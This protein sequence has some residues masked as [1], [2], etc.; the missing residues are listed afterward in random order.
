[1]A[2]YKSVREVSAVIVNWQSY[3]LVGSCIAALKAGTS[4][5]PLEIIVI[6]NSQDEVGRALLRQM[7]D[8]RVEWI[9]NLTNVGFAAACNQGIG[10]A[11]SDYVL[12]I[13]PDA[14]VHER[15]VDDMAQ[16]IDLHP[17]LAA[18]GAQLLNPDGTLQPSA[19]RLY[20]GLLRAFLDLT[21]LRYAWLFIRRSRRNA[22]ER[23]TVTLMQTAWLKGACMMIR[24]EAFD[25]I[26]P[27]DESFFLFAEDVDWCYRAHRAGWQIALATDCFATHVGERSMSK[28]RLAGISAYYA[29]YLHFILKHQ[30][31]GPLGLRSAAARLLL[32]LGAAT[33]LIAFA[34][35]SLFRPERRSNAQAYWRYLTAH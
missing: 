15:T 31:P 16:L 9:F 23:E 5:I 19:Y 3:D 11:R 6:D 21:G 26:G 7:S 27:L 12:L 22:A 1:L 4:H 33:R 34:A 25:A 2:S 24:R 20:P 32:K 30:G 8:K 14:V 13:N 17:E 28:D 18:V 35:A 29:S 10:H